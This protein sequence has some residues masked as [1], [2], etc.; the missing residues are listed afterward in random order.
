MLLSADPPEPP[1]TLTL[2][3]KHDYSDKVLSA[4]GGAGQRVGIQ[5]QARGP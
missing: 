5:K 1:H 3:I 4:R 2:A